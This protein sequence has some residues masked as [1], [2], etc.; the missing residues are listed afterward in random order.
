MDLQTAVAAIDWELL[1]R[2]T[3]VPGEVT[4]RRLAGA[5]KAAAVLLEHAQD[6]QTNWTDADAAR[7][8]SACVAMLPHLAVVLGCK[9]DDTA[10][11]SIVAAA[12]GQADWDLRC[13]PA[14]GCG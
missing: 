8:L 12:Q 7:L 5:A 4:A 10:F 14:A 2:A 3:T 9:I 1:S 11:A 6:E 13:A